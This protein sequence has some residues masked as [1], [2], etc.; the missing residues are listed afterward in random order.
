M[1]DIYFDSGEDKDECPKCGVLVMPQ[2]SLTI[3]INLRGAKWK[4]Q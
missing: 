2:F 3:Q 4:R 1:K